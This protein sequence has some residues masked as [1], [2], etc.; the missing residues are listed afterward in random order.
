[1]ITRTLARRLER[2]EA[3]LAPPDDEPALRI[4]V[5]SPGQASPTKLSKCARASRPTIGDDRGQC[6]EHLRD[7]NESDQHAAPPCLR[8][9]NLGLGWIRAFMIYVKSIVAWIVAVAT[10]TILAMV[11]VLWPVMQMS[12]NWHEA[13][14]LTALGTVTDG[15]TALPSHSLFKYG[16]AVAAHPA[17]F[18]T[19]L[20]IIHR[21][22][23][24]RPWPC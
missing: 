8:F 20:N 6:A 14:S 23:R 19:S 18:Q 10:A 1:M 3:E 15:T 13:V 17:A 5:T 22:R 24:Q 7:G 2:L 16:A 21:D 4:L 9:D 12:G 11:I